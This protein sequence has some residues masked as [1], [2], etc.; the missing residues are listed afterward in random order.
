MPLRKGFLSHPTPHT[1]IPTAT[2]GGRGRALRQWEEGG[3]G[4]CSCGRGGGYES[5]TPEPSEDKEGAE[6]ER[7]REREKLGQLS[8][9][10]VLNFK[11]TTL[12]SLR[13]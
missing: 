10:L 4:Y 8:G 5:L 6:R 9:P 3:A 13:D 12:T 1:H 2:H 11:G 7:E